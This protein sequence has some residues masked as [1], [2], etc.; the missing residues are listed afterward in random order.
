M[1]YNTRNFRKELVRLWN[2]AATMKKV[3]GYYSMKLWTETRVRNAVKMG[4]ITQ[5]E[6]EEITGKAY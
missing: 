5:A 6:F 4:W 3:R 2:T 1:C